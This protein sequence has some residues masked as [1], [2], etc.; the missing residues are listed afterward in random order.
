MRTIN[1][2]NN[3]NRN[4]IYPKEN[5]LD[6]AFNYTVEISGKNSGVLL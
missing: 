6:F 1:T 5:F 2:N 3:G 4:K